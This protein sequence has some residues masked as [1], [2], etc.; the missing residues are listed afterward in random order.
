[1]AS[2]V[3][4]GAGEVAAA[5]LA[6]VLASASLHAAD[7]GEAAQRIVEGTNALRKAQDREVLKVSPTLEQAA[8]DFAH[9]MAQ[10]GKYGHGADGRQPVDRAKAKGY[11]HCIV[12]EN[13]AYQ[14]RSSGYDTATLARE[15]V[16]GWKHSPEHRKNMLDPE[17]TETGVGLAQDAEGRY[18]AVQM[19]GLPK[20]AAVTFSVSNAA[21]REVRYRIGEREYSL[22]PRGRRTHLEC[23]APE[24]RLPGAREPVTP[25]DGAS[26]AIGAR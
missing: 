2:A 13:L 25:E 20:A 6:A 8:V 3:D 14:Y 17:L 26:F 19:F 24:L 11:E 10:T 22:P 7:T 12:S 5:M 23:R 15:L 9:Y 16:E 18:F 21:G 1:M 4:R